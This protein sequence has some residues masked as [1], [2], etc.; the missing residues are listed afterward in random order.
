MEKNDNM[1]T[2]LEGV[3]VYVFTDRLLLHEAL[4]HRSF[5]N[6]TGDRSVKDNE[7]LEFF[8]DA[9]LG[10]F[11]S[12]RLMERFPESREGELTRIRASLV[13]EESLAQLAAT[14]NLG[15]YLRL[16]RGEEKSGGR[17]KKSIL[18]DAYE[19]LLAAVYLD[20]GAAPVRRMIEAHFA[21]LMDRHAAGMVSRDYK[22]EF[23]MLAQARLGATPHYVLKETAGPDHERYFTVETFV[24]K[25]CLGEGSGRSKKEAEQA[26]ASEG[27][28]RLKAAATDKG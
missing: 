12:N 9:V 23:Q 16:G 7:R 26:A 6:E 4:T 8:G 28:A 10:F 27:Y 2:E 17:G 1:L 3:I 14:I 15:R 5:V 11:L 24:G 22:T 19:A 20:G 25:E 18:A 13:D 21:P